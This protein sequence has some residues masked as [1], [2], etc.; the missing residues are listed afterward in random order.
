MIKKET[1]VWGHGHI[2]QEG[3]SEAPP[4]IINGEFHA[5]SEAFGYHIFDQ[6]SLDLDDIGQKPESLSIVTAV[7]SIR[8]LTLQVSEIG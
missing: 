2:S 7:E 1:D 4:V 5:S 6:E 8:T 3:D